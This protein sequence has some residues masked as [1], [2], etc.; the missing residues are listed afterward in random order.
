ML[1]DRELFVQLIERDF[2]NIYQQLANT[3]PMLNIPMVQEKI[4]GYG[5]ILIGKAADLFFGAQNSNGIEEAIEIAKHIT[6]NKIEEY[7]TKILQAKQDGSNQTKEQN[8]SN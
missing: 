1:S 8:N 6:N 2:L 4:F 3:T 7:R 5:D